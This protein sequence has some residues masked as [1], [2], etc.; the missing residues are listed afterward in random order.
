MDSENE[1]FCGEPALIHSND[2]P[3]QSNLFI[4]IQ[5]RMMSLSQRRKLNKESG[6]LIKHRP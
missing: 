4:T 1:V 2:V 5:M 3:G 6:E